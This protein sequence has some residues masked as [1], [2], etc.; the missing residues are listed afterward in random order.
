MSVRVERAQL[1]ISC[2]LILFRMHTSCGRVDGLA[3]VDLESVE[4]AGHLL[5]VE[6]KDEMG[7]PKGA[8]LVLQW[9]QEQNGEK[10]KRKE[11][12]G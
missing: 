12:G 6:K 11:R 8:L 4:V 2:R 1:G 3:G 7:V 10:E 5:V 9:L